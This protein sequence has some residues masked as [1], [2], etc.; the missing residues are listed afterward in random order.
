[1][2]H[3]AGESIYEIT[4]NIREA[5]PNNYET[6]KTA[7][8]E[9]FAPLANPDYEQFLLRQ[10]RQ[11]AEESVDEF[12]AR[13]KKLA[14]TSTLPDE[15][16]EI[17]AQFIQGCAS[18]KLREQILQDPRRSMDDILTLGRSKELSKARASHMEAA[19]QK[20]IKI[21]PVSLV[22][23]GRIP[24]KKDQQKP[25]PLTRTCRWCGGTFPHEGECP[26]KGK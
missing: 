12:Y 4:Q 9:Y 19:L 5:T 23:K 10:A 14:S 17:R 21:E 20:P 16:H 13:L 1:M 22:T 2:L 26:A 6:L 8:T 3:L 18:N 25:Q 24:E 11:K 15:Q 7:L